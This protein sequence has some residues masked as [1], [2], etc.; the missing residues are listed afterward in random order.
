MGTQKVNALKIAS[1]THRMLPLK[2]NNNNS[3]IKNVVYTS[4]LCTAQVR[5]QF[6][7]QGVTCLSVGAALSTTNTTHK[8]C[9]LTH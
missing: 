5:T 7:V 8:V 4:I 6:S 9:T 1:T 3:N 2:L